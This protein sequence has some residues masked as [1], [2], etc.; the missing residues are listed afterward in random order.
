[1]CTNPI[2]I[3]NNRLDYD[4]FNHKKY[5]LVPCGECDECRKQRIQQFATRLTFENYATIQAGGINVFLTF[6]YNYAHVPYLCLSGYHYNNAVKCFD[7]KHML[8]LLRALHRHYAKKGLKF[9]HFVCSEYGDNTK[10]PHYHGLFNL[11]PGIDPLEF[12][13]CARKYW[14]RGIYGNLGFMFPSKSG[15]KILNKH[16]VRSD[17][18]AGRYVAK[19]AV[20]DLSF[21]KIPIIEYISRD[22]R[23][24]SLYKDYLPKTYI[25][26]NLGV[27]ALPLVK[28]DSEFL[29]CP[30]TGKK[31][32][33]PRYYFDK[34][35]YNIRSHVG[36]NKKFI[37][38]SDTTC[39]TYPR[40]VER[41]KTDFWYK[42]DIVNFE[43]CILNKAQRYDAY[44]E[45]FG[46]MTDSLHLAIYHYFYKDRPSSFWRSIDELSINPWCLSD[47]CWA[48]QILDYYGCEDSRL[49]SLK[50]RLGYRVSLR[51][52]T[53]YDTDDCFTSVVYGDEYG[54]M[55]RYEYL[56][57]LKGYFDAPDINVVEYDCKLLD[58][59]INTLQKESCYEYV[60]KQEIVKSLRDEPFSTDY[61]D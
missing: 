21:Y 61:L 39:V 31:L 22:K 27:S 11:P 13:E 55:S 58:D 15:C 51:G 30:F 24:K 32:T 40:S 2:R 37:F 6:T 3:K 38:S 45:R 36:D 8:Y 12:S 53:T 5:L 16:I 18:Y 1:M 52:A 48:H 41:L 60:Q 9:K 26:N 43:R 10:H 34:L 28:A 54:D 7:S 50:K 56:C 33:I 20:K 44:K 23:L 57:T 4:K 42:K 46:I 25:S 35:S 59:F 49:L 47:V 14:T 29:L 19:Y 17:S